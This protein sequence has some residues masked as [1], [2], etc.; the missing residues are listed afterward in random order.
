[1]WTLPDAARRAGTMNHYQ[2]LGV[3]RDAQPDVIR[4]AY[5]RRARTAHPD[6]TGSV[7]DDEMSAINEAWFVLR[8][9]ERRR[10]YDDVLLGAAPSTG[11][12][13]PTQVRV[14][15][16]DRSP[17][18]PASALAGMVGAAIVLTVAAA[19]LFL[20]IALLEGH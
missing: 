8:D 12:D 9:P 3:A 5:R 19:A 16:G 7:D 10:R 18:R 14:R 15:F 2:R 4:D 13:R 17:G 6:A 11:A 20:L 1:M